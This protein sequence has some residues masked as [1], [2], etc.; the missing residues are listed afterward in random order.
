MVHAPHA[1]DAH[2]RHL[3]KAHH[4][5]YGKEEQQEHFHLTL[6]VLEPPIPQLPAGKETVMVGPLRSSLMRDLLA[7]QVI[8]RLFTVERGF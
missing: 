8:I 6:D 7:L 3:A 2:Q 1:A 5:Q 4:L